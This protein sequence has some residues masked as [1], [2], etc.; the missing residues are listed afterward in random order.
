MADKSKRVSSESPYSSGGRVPVRLFEFR[1]RP[2]TFLDDEQ[3]RP[4]HQGEE[5]LL[6]TLAQ[7]QE[8]RMD[9]ILVDEMT[10]HSASSSERA[11]RVGRHPQRRNSSGWCR[12][13]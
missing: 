4:A 6:A 13:N 7:L 11:Q 1:E 8:G 12:I 9:W 2:V 3:V 10:A 5:H